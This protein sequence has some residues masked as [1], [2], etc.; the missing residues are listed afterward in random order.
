MAADR[1][2]IRVF[3]CS[4]FRDMHAERDYLNRMIFPELRSR[5]DRA[6][7]TFVALDLRWGVTDEESRRHGA[8]QICL[9]EIER[10]RPFFLCLLGDLYG[11]TPPPEKVATDFFAASPAS[12]CL[13]TDKR[14]LLERLYDLDRALEPPIFRFR[15]A[16]PP[17]PEDADAAVRLW[18][19]L[20][21]PDA[22]ASITAREILRGALDVDLSATRAYF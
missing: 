9:D 6:G 17:P 7:A 12:D 21:L 10:C 14:R 18:E 11:W 20:G 4:T 3:V 1:R 13:V 5:C 19:R 2:A 15:R 16:P 8:L 22:G